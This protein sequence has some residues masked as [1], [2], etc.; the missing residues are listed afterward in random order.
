MLG[1]VLRRLGL[2]IASTTGIK[3][4]HRENIFWLFKKGGEGAGWN[5]VV[6]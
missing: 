6:G 2:Q 3:D 4:I 5:A 1:V